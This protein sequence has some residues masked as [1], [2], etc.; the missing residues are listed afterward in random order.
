MVSQI[1]VKKAFVSA[2]FSA[3]HLTLQNS[4]MIYIN[5]RVSSLGFR[6]QFLL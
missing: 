4:H 6:Q 2:P 3:L 1:Y 5:A